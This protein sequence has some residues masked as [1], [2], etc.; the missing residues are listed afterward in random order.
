MSISLA[1][2][3]TS[4]ELRDDR[5]REMLFETERFAAATVSAKVDAA[6]LDGME[7]GQSMHLTV[8]GN[9]SLHGESRPLPMDLVIART[10]DHM[11]LVTSEKPVVVNAP[12][13]KLAEGVEALREIAGLPSI[14]TAVPV[15]FVLTFNRD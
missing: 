15:S 12:E 9:L 1:S 11:L 4:I 8:E 7:P 14:S 3:D 13:F 6:A 2:V 5:M 10:G